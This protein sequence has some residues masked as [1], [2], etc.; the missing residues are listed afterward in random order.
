METLLQTTRARI[1]TA[2]KELQQDD[3]EI[4]ER[5]KKAAWERIG[6][7]HIVSVHTYVPST[8]TTNNSQRCMYM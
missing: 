4:R 1:E 8:D 2:I 5:L 6:E 7:D 3:P